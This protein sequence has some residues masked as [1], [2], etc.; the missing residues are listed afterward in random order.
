MENVAQ[1]S[2]SAGTT[3][4]APA[5][6]VSTL[7]N[8][9]QLRRLTPG[10][11]EYRTA[12]AAKLGKTPEASV[13]STGGGQKVEKTETV[14]STPASGETKTETVEDKAMWSARAQKR[15]EEALNDRT[16]AEKERDALKAR[17]AELEGK[18]PTGETPTATPTGSTFDKPKPSRE[19]PKFKT[20]ADYEEALVDWKFE[21]KDF[22]RDQASTARRIQEEQKADSDK[23]K[24]AGKEL[25]KELGLS[26][27]DFDHTMNS[28]EAAVFSPAA[29]YELMKSEH[30]A[31]IAYEIVSDPDSAKAFGKMSPAQQLR[32]I[33]RLEGKIEAQS[34]SRETPKA[35]S[36]AKAPSTPLQKGS[37]PAR[38]GSIFK[39]GMSV[40]EYEAARRERKGQ[41]K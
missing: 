37:A 6:D 30:G 31:R 1:N 26:P 15:I 7:V 16:A 19:D 21:K 3:P 11:A 13:T 40:A 32:Q 9:L 2:P 35:V 10:T 39:P 12:L 33:G 34:K 27:G 28:K 18:K 5:K 4:A 24:A 23:F 17:V 41:S 14:V 38:V 20:Q 29:N 8:D 22:E 25:E 36:G